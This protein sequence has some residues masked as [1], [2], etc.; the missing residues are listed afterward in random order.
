MCDLAFRLQC[1]IGQVCEEVV[2]VPQINSAW[3][4]ALAIWGQYGMSAEEQRRRTLAR[5]L[6]SSSVRAK[7]ATHKLLKQVKTGTQG[8]SLL[9]KTRTGIMCSPFS[10]T[11][12]LFLF[13]GSDRSPL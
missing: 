13:S 6:D 9:M 5:S 2:H 3:E 7:A 11:K 4:N 1:E 10:V 8:T 12:M